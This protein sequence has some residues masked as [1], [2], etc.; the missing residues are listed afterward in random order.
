MHIIDK[1]TQ[2]YQDLNQIDDN[3]TIDRYKF[4]NIYPCTVNELKLLGY[5]ENIVSAGSAPSS[6]LSSSASLLTSTSNGTSLLSSVSGTLA[7]NSIINNGSGNSNN[8]MSSNNSNQNDE[9]ASNKVNSDK[10]DSNA[11]NPFSKLS[12]RKLTR[13]PVP[14]V[15]KMFPFKPNRNAFSG[16]QPV[17]GGGLFLFPSCIAEMIK[18]LPAPSGFDVCSLINSLKLIIILIILF[19][20]KKKLKG[21]ICNY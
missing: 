8:M 9:T 19:K 21:S 12:S 1:R 18:R 2:L 5:S 4:L 15:N 14:D 17:A 16:L 7:I 6:L 3:Q 10:F 11:F 13:F 20:F